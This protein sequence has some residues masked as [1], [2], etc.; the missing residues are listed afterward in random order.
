[1]TLRSRTS[2]NLAGLLLLTP[3]LGV[4]G[5]DTED[6]T[7]VVVDNDFPQVPDGGDAASET[8]VFKV[9]WATSLMP[10]PVA[11]G[12]EGQPQRT[13]P[14]ADFAYAVLARGWDPSSSSAPTKLLAAKSL[15]ILGAARGDTLHVHVSEGTFAGDCTAGQ[16]LSQDDADFIA[17]RIF[18]AEFA[19]M[20]YDAA[21][22]GASGAPDG[23]GGAPDGAGGE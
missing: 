21:T 5:C 17:T 7:M 1:M 11:P 3:L 18:P 4:V 22:C 16:P 6:P 13:V 14:D 20:T 15:V 10:D 2:M 19:G 8:T 23:A 12:A 9:W